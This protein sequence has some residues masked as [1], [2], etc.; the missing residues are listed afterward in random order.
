FRR[1]I[2][3]SRAGYPRVTHPCATVPGPKPFLVRLACVRRAA[4]VRSEPG[5]NSP[6]E[7]V[8]ASAFA[9]R[10]GTKELILGDPTRCSCEP[11]AGR[12]DRVRNGKVTFASP[13]RNGRGGIVPAGSPL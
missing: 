2:H 1:V 11:V 12:P 6:V 4:N 7:F 5:S 8:A 10:L 13:D 3:H 9:V